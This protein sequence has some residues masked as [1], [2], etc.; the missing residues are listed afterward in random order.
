MLRKAG[1]DDIAQMIAL[2]QMKRAE[3]ESFA[4]T[5]W[6][7][8]QDAAEK[9]TPF[10]YA[11]LSRENTFCLV[12]ERSGKIDGF[13]IATVVAAPPVYDPGSPVCMIDDFVVESPDLWTTVGRELLQEARRLTQA[14]GAKLAVVVCGHLDE[15]KRAMLTSAGLYVA[16]EWYVSP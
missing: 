6:R 9:Q 13:I 1:E 4:P 10:F 15:S 16:S 5:F 11:Q 7:Q 8:A 12:Y 14:H 3:Y 2:A